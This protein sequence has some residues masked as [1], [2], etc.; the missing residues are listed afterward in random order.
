MFSSVAALF[1]PVGQS[2]HA[3]ANAF[4]DSFAH[5]RRAL[6]LPALSIQWGGWKD[7]GAAA[8]LGE[9]LLSNGVKLIEPHKG[10]W[11]LEGI[12]AAAALSAGI[13]RSGDR[14]EVE[15]AAVIACASLDWQAYRKARGGGGTKMP[16]LDEIVATA[17]TSTEP[18]LNAQ[19]E[20]IKSGVELKAAPSTRGDSIGSTALEVAR[21]AVAQGDR[22]SVV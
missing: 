4:E 7:V 6:G 5:Y 9:G 13:P 14:T 10:V 3:A 15:D 8:R 17:S 22:K 20:T 19:A 16:W 21:N 11:A 2:N 12:I 18:T 1:G